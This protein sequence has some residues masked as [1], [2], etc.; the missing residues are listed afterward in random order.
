MG[1]FGPAVAYH[2]TD[3]YLNQVAGDP[4][5]SEHLLSAIRTVPENEALAVIFRRHNH[6][7]TMLAYLVTYFAWPRRVISVPIEDND[8]IGQV[9]SAL[10]DQLA[11]TFYCGITP[12]PYLKPILTIGDSLT[13]VPRL[14]SKGGIP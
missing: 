5:G 3:R 13:M 14:E 11:A 6:A 7:D 8:A 2:T 9:E 10:P 4:F 1:R 12:S